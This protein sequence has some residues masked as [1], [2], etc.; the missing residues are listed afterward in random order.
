MAE[1]TSDPTPLLT[2]AVPAYQRPELLRRALASIVEAIPE[3]SVVEVLISDNSPDLSEVE[4]ERFRPNW[5]G[6]FT[7][8]K[9]EPMIDRTA[10]FNQCITAASGRYLLYLHD[11]DFLFPDAGRGLLAALRRAPDE[12]RIFLFGVRVVNLSGSVRRRQTHRRERRLEPA[13]ALRRVLTDSSYV[14][15]PALVVRRDAFDEVGMFDASANLPADFDLEVRL[16]ARFGV[17]LEPEVI[18][19]YTVHPA[20]ITTGMFHPGTIADLLPI[21]DRA[22]GLGV[23]PP[24][25]VRRCQRDFLH[26]FALGG[27]YRKLESGDRAGAAE[28]LKLL[29]LPVVRSLGISWRWLPVRL[30]FALAVRVPFPWGR[31]S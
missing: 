13:E 5:A 26:Q 28:V 18:A 1:P 21:F 16:F 11:D 24:R 29:D 25:V 7:Y 31:R 19:G 15:I 2:I 23:L 14:R 3:P 10:N 6:K 27:V 12:D 17:R 4:V 8:I 20:G 30:A 9:N 22:A